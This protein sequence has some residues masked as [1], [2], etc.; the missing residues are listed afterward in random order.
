M[1]FPANNSSKRDCEVVVAIAMK[2]GSF[3]GKPHLAQHKSHLRLSCGVTTRISSQGIVEFRGGF[4]ETWKL[5][6]RI[7]L[8][9]TRTTCIPSQAALR[10][11][12]AGLPGRV[13]SV[14]PFLR[15]F[16][17]PPRSRNR[18]ATALSFSRT[19]FRGT[20]ADPTPKRQIIFAS[21]NKTCARLER[22]QIDRINGFLLLVGQNQ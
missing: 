20:G 17:L 12:T 1:H 22:C 6:G 16:D 19:G 21:I 11:E 10:R 9:R 2:M 18:S 3:R 13:F 7:S 8:Y 15:P 5:S 14:S 4:H